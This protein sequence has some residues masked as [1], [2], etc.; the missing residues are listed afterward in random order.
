MQVSLSLRELRTAHNVTKRSHKSVMPLNT[1][2]PSVLKSGFKK[3]KIFKALSPNRA[4]KP[5]LEETGVEYPFDTDSFDESDGMDSKEVDFSDSN[6]K[7]SLSYG[8]LTSY[9]N[10]S[11]SEDEDRIYYQSNNTKNEQV[12][13]GDLNV[14]SIDRSEKQILKRSIFPWKKRKLS[15]RSF[16]VKGEPLLKRDVREEGGDDIDFDR[17][18]L[19]SSDDSSHGVIFLFS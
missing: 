11:G 4:K 15:F 9:F 1:D 6:I 8:T 16:K 5:C 12:K 10:S 14:S 17:R 13:M 2:E 19:T 18:M 3:V 7:K